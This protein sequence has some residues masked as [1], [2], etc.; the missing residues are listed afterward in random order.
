MAKIML[1]G[2]EK[3]RAQLQGRSL[4]GH[5]LAKVVVGYR[6]P[7]AIR[8]HEDHSLAHPN[9]GQAKYLEQPARMERP[10]MR[11]IIRQRLRDKK[12]SLDN[13]CKAAGRY[14]L[15]K[16]LPLVPRD[17]GALAKSGFVRVE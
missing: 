1:L 4:M 12:K 8:Q 11:Q 6:A 3:V 10:A 15:E 9:G 2:A 7:Y 14:L 17:T 13:A 5:V 16:S